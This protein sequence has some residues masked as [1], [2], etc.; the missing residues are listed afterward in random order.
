MNFYCTDLEDLIIPTTFT[1]AP[2]TTEMDVPIQAV[3]NQ[4]L[5]E[6]RKEFRM[7]IESVEVINGSDALKSSRIEGEPVMITVYENDCE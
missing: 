6:K 3:D 1:F 4:I 7:Y 5:S 2:S